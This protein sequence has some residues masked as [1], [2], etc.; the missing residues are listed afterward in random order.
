MEISVEELVNL[1][2]KINDAQD[3]A[4]KKGFTASEERELPNNLFEALLKYAKKSKTLVDYHKNG[5]G[6]DGCNWIQ[7]KPTRTGAEDIEYVE[8]SFELNKNEIE[9]V[10]AKKKD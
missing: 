1:Q 5:G 9:Y 3:S 2:N 7:L 6:M 4:Y 8:I 10:G